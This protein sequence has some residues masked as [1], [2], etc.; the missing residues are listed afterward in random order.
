MQ[1]PINP[2]QLS[3]APHRV[4]S[5]FAVNRAH[6]GHLDLKVLHAPGE[7]A[8]TAGRGVGHVDAGSARG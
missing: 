4:A 2:R 6:R 3:R 7:I 5:P 1:T 8:V